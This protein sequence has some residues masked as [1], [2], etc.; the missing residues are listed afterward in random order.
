[1][2]VGGGLVAV[3]TAAVLTRDE[4]VREEREK[5]VEAK[6]Q[7]SDL[8][9]TLVAQQRLKGVVVK[10]GP[11]PGVGQD[12]I[13]GRSKPGE[14]A[15]ANNTSTSSFNQTPERPVDQTATATTGLESE[16]QT[17]RKDAPPGPA[18]KSS[19]NNNNSNS[20]QAARNSI[21]DRPSNANRKAPSQARQ[22]RPAA[23][24]RQFDPNNAFLPAA[25]PPKPETVAAERASVPVAARTVSQLWTQEISSDGSVVMVPPPGTRT[26]GSSLML[27]SDEQGNKDN[28]SAAHR[29][30]KTNSLGSSPPPPPPPPP[31]RAKKTQAPPSPRA[32][33]PPPKSPRRA[34][35]TTTTKKSRPATT[36][37]KPP[38]ATSARARA[39][40]AKTPKPPPKRAAP[41]SGATT[42]G[43]TG[44]G[45]EV[46][47]RRKTP[48]ADQN[49]SRP[50]PSSVAP[51]L[52]KGGSISARPP[53]PK[54]RPKP[55][56]K[57]LPQPQ[58]QRA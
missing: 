26:R 24:P 38:P 23:A 19:Q 47:G 11:S 33:P 7:E 10:K 27:S 21:A 57:P 30:E 3:A 42:T 34:A 53:L 5:V 32:P 18:P 16:T 48:A 28:E 49:R 36:T 25:P 13:A 29:R 1:M 15:V 50:K 9:K 12:E 8:S 14:P 2:K 31:R 39:A 58:P 41:S 56:P 37:T 54:T 6:T 40:P 45:D 51:E 17:R 44:Q 35:V 43:R 4:G 52:K 22:S 46:G 55:K 20:L